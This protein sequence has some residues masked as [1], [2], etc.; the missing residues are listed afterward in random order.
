LKEIEHPTEVFSSKEEEDETSKTLDL[1]E[2]QKLLCIFVSE[3]CTPEIKSLLDHKLENEN[4]SS[5]AL[6]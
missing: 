5:R 3:H 2:I 1:K 6:C 4:L